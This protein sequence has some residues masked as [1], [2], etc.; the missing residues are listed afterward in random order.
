MAYK[1]FLKN[2]G[3][4]AR[5]GVGFLKNAKPFTTTCGQIT[6]R[7]ATGKYTLLNVADTS[8]FKDGDLI[9]V[10]GAGGATLFDTTAQNVTPT[11]IDVTEGYVQDYASGTVSQRF[12]PPKKAGLESGLFASYVSNTNDVLRL[13]G[14]DTSKFPVGA[15]I[16]ILS[17]DRLIN[18]SATIT[19]S[20]GATIDTNKAY[21]G[22]TGGGG[23]I[24]NTW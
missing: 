22:A 3:T 9:N 15:V 8:G 11:Y 18:T 2:T 19:A 6:Q 12:N 16:T 1:T 13:E 7:G 23:F 14:A 5:A 24:S 21:L 20:S 17:D 10:R 4:T